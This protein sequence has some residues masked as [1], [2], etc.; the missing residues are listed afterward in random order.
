[1]KTQLTPDENRIDGN[2]IVK[3]TKVTG[4]SNCQRIENLIKSYL[5]KIGI[6]QSGWDTLFRDPRDGRYWELVY[7]HSEMHGGG[8]P[9]LIQIDARMAAQKYNHYTSFNLI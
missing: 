2:W 5:Q 8:P 7:L 9:S 4:D 1:M 3:G 6:D